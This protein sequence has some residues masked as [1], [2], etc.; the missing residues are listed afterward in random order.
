MVRPLNV[1]W[2]LNVM[3]PTDPY[4]GIL[5]ALKVVLG[6]ICVRSVMSN[7]LQPYGL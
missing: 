7:S 5:T 4:V 6:C 3:S 2:G 1:C